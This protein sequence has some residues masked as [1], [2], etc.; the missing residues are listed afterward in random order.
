MTEADSTIAS[1]DAFPTQAR[2]V[3]IGGGV[4]G[5]SVAYHL[6]KL[7]WRDVVL[8]E[9]SQL[10]A[11]TTWHAAG[12]IVTGFSSETTISIAKYTR[13]LYARLGEETGQDTGFKPVGYIQIASNP[14]R[15][16]VLRRRADFSRMFG[17][18]TEEISAAEI[19]KMWPLFETDDILSGF[20]TPDDG[21]TNPIDTAMA[22]AKGAK[23]GGAC[24][25]EETKVTG[26]KQTNGRVTGVV[27][28]RGEIEAEYVVNCGG[29]WA[30]EIGKM[31]GVNVPLHAAE[32][33]YLITEPIEGIH[34]DMPI[35]EDPDLFGYY[36]EEMGGLM[37]GLF[38]PVAGPWGMV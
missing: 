9:R 14:D 31:A 19:K 24:I 30:R 5:C 34:R 36:R 32:H 35:V 13:D 15:V 6:T 3:I 12:L 10:T 23:M 7:G 20:Y 33:Y 25:W 1:S 21:R 38:E 8:L 27:T 16:D 4:V 28:D 37:L 22:M 26:I 11:G 29:M 17:V 18:Y 2:V